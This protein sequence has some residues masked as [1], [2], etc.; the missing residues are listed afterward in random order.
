MISTA[1]EEFIKTIPT[2]Q[3]TE[4]FIYA[5]LGVFVLSLF[6][7]RQNKHQAFTQYTP[8]LLTSLGMLGTFTGIVAG[9][10]DFNPEDLDS[11]IGPLLEGLKTAFITSLGGM[12]LSILYKSIVSSGVF[13]SPASEEKSPDEV[14]AADLLEEMKSQSAGIELL[15]K[16]IAGDGDDSLTGQFKQLR[17]DLSDSQKKV[18]M[19]LKLTAEAINK[20]NETATQQQTDF[21][22]FQTKLWKELQNFAELLS[23]SATE[24][25]MEALKKT[26]KEFNQNLMDQFGDNFK[27]LNAAVKDLVT[28]QE[29]YRGQLED[30]KAQYDH[31]VTAITQ[32]Q[33][34]VEQIG[35]ECQRIPETMDNLS[36]LINKNQEQNEELENS[37]GA[38]ATIREKAAEAIPVIG[39]QLDK[40]QAGSTR[41]A[42]VLEEGSTQIEQ[43]C[44]EGSRLLQ[45]AASEGSGS[46]KKGCQELFE[47][48]TDGAEAL[49]GACGTSGAELVRKLDQAGNDFSGS[50]SEAGTQ[51][52][53][54]V[55]E[56]AEAIQGACTVSGETLISKVTQ[57]AD[58]LNRECAAAGDILLKQ[59]KGAA[60]DFSAKCVD[61]GN[62]ILIKSDEGAESLKQGCVSAGQ[63][64]TN[65]LKAGAADFLKSYK[66]AC[67]SL[68]AE[69][70][71]AS[72]LLIGECENITTAMKAS[73]ERQIAEHQNKTD[74]AFNGLKEHIKEVHATTAEAVTE[75][76]GMLDKSMEE[77][78]KRALGVMGGHLATIVEKF[79]Q[80][81]KVL[82][83]EMEKVINDI[84][85]RRF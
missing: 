26:V 23:K 64:F 40:L 22:E 60:E 29:N 7:K 37:F 84:N 20:L 80:D 58:T 66:E 82:V 2:N 10:L 5:L 63:E 33:G 16:S 38:F 59:V 74:Q 32:T 67:D 11:S 54:K 77:E 12:F 69:T 34:A 13:N 30:M 49:S 55:K 81:Y 31:G 43:G 36:T 14:G 76:I 75:K 70:D 65:S 57:G 17:T 61:S 68:N 3:I 1:I 72:K 4:Y 27:E 62:K 47:K 6:W 52:S 35:S 78:L 44:S 56:G 53:A 25:V 41:L 15:R 79:T 83:S 9:L 51:L 19:H 48:V 21:G 46:I 73:I 24:Q 42:N 39:E 28:W 50:C 8:T 18:D 71:K 45:D 85:G